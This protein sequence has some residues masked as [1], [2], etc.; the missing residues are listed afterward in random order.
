LFSL[1]LHPSTDREDI[2]IADLLECGTAG[3]TEDDAGVRAF[4]ERDDD[5]D[6]ITATFR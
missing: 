5:A 2:L 3:V 6:V 1:L 4:F